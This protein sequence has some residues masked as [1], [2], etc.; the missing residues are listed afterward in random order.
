MDPAIVVQHVDELAQAAEKLLNICNCDR[1]FAFYGEMGVGKTAFIKEICKQ[2]GVKENVT[3]PSFAI[4]NEYKG[5]F[6]VFHIDTY[7][8]NEINEATNIG[9][10]EYFTKGAYCFVEWPSKIEFLLPL[11]T[12]KISIIAKPDHTRIITIN[13]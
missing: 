12:I 10:E 1:N 6:Q 5:D 2:L 7:R 3:S 13:D 9:L 4:V 8:L 11:D